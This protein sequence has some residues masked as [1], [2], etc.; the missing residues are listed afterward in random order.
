MC[1]V[2][3]LATLADVP[4]AWLTSPL[5]EPSHEQLR[6]DTIDEALE[7]CESQLL[8]AAAPAT[9]ATHPPLTPSKP[10]APPLG[11][12]ESSPQRHH[13]PGSR[14]AQVPS[15][16]SSVL[17][18]LVEAEWTGMLEGLAP[19][20]RERRYSAGA[21]IFRKGALAHSI[22]LITSGEVRE[23]RPLPMPITQNAPP[24]RWCLEGITRCL[25]LL[26]TELK[27]CSRCCINLD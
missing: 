27:A 22:Y 13:T 12:L 23:G 18:P 1:P 4:E 19:F 11:G 8:S 2:Q 3:P 15:A 16:L 17:I 24:N 5:F 21:I 25:L 10:V 6:F 9:D 14:G 20:F 26:K 7:F